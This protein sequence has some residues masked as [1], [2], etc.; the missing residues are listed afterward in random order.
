[1][2]KIF[3]FILCA[4]TA[5]SPLAVFTGAEEEKGAFDIDYSAYEGTT[6]N[7]YNW[8]EYISDGSEGTY[9]VVAEFE[10]LTGIRVNYETYDSNESMYAKLDSGAANYDIIIPS[11]YMI[12]R[13]AEEGM[14]EELDYSNIPNYRYIDDKYKGLFFDPDNKYTAAY[15][16]GYVGLIYNTEVVT[17]TPSSWS[18]MWDEQ[19]I[20]QILMPNNPRDAFGVAQ[21]L[22]GGQTE[23]PD[24]YSVNS[25]NEDE[26][27][28]ALNKLKDQKPLVKGYVMDEI[29]NKMESGDAAIAAYYAGD[30]LTMYATNDS[31]AFVYPD[32]GTNV[33]VDAMCIP[34]GAKNKAAAELFINFMLEPEVAIANA[35]YICYAS[36]CSSVYT[37]PGYI[38]TMTEMHEDAMEILYG[39]EDVTAQYF[40]NMS[41]EM[42]SM[43]NHLW[44]ELKID[45]S[46]GVGVNIAS[47]V[48]VAGLITLIALN[49]YTKKKRAKY[50]N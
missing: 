19:Y 8:G 34:K 43:M 30:F 1:M 33:F 21:Y 17:E 32:E 44:E 27:Y 25:S 13:L 5:L 29:F 47:G 22:L 2:K 50:Y 40:E 10:A 46:S 49:A 41:P 31:L 16:A 37:D 35:E 18:I 28:N 45:A 6:L 23:D 38:E 15:T 9:D 48:I 24:D 36:P 42:L 26:W 7:V 12:Q 4:V 39:T 11:D 14:L 20:G 3:C